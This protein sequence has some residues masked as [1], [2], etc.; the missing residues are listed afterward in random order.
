M[1]V[2]STRIKLDHHVALLGHKLRIIARQLIE[3]NYT[4]SSQSAP[5]VLVSHG[6]KY[7]F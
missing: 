2:K 6:T 1:T 7:R 3:M 4:A 5:N